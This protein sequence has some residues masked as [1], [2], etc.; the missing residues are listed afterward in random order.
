MNIFT[1]NCEGLGSKKQEVDKLIVDLD[2]VAFCLQDTRL[3]K[4]RE[5]FFEF[6]NY[7]SYFKSI[8]PTASGVALYIKKN[9][10][11]SQVTFTTNLQAGAARATM[12][13]KTYILSSN[14]FPPPPAQ[15]LQTLMQ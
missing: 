7:K 15:Q 8:G 6:N 4:P 5:K 9:I 1:W 3:T 11:Q 13:G 10:P 14:M 12:K 2:P